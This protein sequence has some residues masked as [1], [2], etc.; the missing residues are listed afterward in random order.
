MSNEV[1]CKSCGEK[2]LDTDSYCK[3]CHASLIIQDHSD[4]L[5]L[6]GI[7]IEKWHKFIGKNSSGYIKDFKKHEG[8][9][10]FISFNP[11]AWIFGQYWML[12]RKMYI[13]ALLTPTVATL[14]AMILTILTTVIS[15]LSSGY[16]NHFTVTLRLYFFN[17][18]S[19]FLIGVFSNSL[20]KAHVKKHVKS[21]YTDFSRG[22]T[23]L[24]PCLIYFVGYFL[25]ETYVI[26]PLV[27]LIIMNIAN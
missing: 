5:P 15:A 8:K 11:A 20:Y 12:Y 1:Y 14:F 9:K 18:L 19:I 13:P 6:E 3:N 2:C 24:T 7:E 17:Y 23:S 10:L 26:S 16:I 21:P 22:G 27:L 4:D 25:I